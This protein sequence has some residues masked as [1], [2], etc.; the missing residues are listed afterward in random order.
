MHFPAHSRFSR[1]GQFK[2]LRIGLG[3]VGDR[4][5]SDPGIQRAIEHLHRLGPRASAEAWVEVL[6]KEGVVDPGVLDRLLR[7]HRLDPATVR[8][9]GGDKFSDRKPRLVPDEDER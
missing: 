5:R 7:W 8:A 4:M 9:I 6:E 1:A 2:P 3:P